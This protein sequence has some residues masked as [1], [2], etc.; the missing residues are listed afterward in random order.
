[1][2]ISDETS[3]KFREFVKLQG[4]DNKFIDREREKRILEEGVMRFE[5]SLNEGRAM[6]LGVAAENGFAVERDAEDRMRIILERFAGTD[7]EIEKREFDDAVAIFQ[8][9]SNGHIRESDARVRLK[10]I[11]EDN[12]WRPKKLGMFRSRKWYRQIAES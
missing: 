5:I 9:F 4:W 11:M 10:K 8:R 7:R 1:M 6:M 2:A 12:G 3:K